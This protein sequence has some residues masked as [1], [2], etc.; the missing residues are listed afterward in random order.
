M[1]FSLAIKYKLSIMQRIS[2]SG[3]IGIHDGFKIR[4]L[5]EWRFK[6]AL[7]HQISEESLNRKIGAFFVL[8][9]KVKQRPANTTCNNSPQ[10][11]QFTVSNTFS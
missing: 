4:F 8:P 5:R 1:H 10:N 3:E 6:S 11:L 9:N 7:G 2:P